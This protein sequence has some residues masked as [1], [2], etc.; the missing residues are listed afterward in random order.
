MHIHP[1]L[2]QTILRVLDFNLGHPAPL[3]FLRRYSKAG[4]ADAKMHTVAKYLMELTL[5]SSTM[6]SYL[7]SEIAAAATFVSRQVVQS[8]VFWTKTIEY[9][10]KYSADDISNCVSDITGVL[11]RSVGSRHQAVTKKFAKRKYLK[12]SKSPEILSFIQSQ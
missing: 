4:H 2:S 1:S 11:K 5:G 10:S 12:I 7:P 3:H 6:L 8:D 9:Y